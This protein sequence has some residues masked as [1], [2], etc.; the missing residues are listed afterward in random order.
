MAT[1]SGAQM[2]EQRMTSLD[3]AEVTGKPHNDVLKAIRKM[4]PTWQKECGGNFSRTSKKVQMP[5]GGVRLHAGDAGEGTQQAPGCGRWR[6]WNWVT[7]SSRRR[8]WRPSGWA[9]TG[10][11][12][13]SGALSC[14]YR[15]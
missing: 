6:R 15:R 8:T 1:M 2:A 11:D 7:R 10:R 12:Q 13:T 9:T 4:E 3:I 14:R 5:Q